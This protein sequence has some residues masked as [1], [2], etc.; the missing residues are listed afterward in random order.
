MENITQNFFFKMNNST[1]TEERKP[2]QS[3]TQESE[4][5]PT[6]KN[7][8]D[9]LIFGSQMMSSDHAMSNVQLELPDDHTEEI[10]PI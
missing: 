3:K 2:T 1:T 7:P 5:T 6:D 9:A 4:T 10:V 8:E